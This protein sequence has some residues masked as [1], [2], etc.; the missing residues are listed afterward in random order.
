MSGHCDSSSVP[1]PSCWGREESPSSPAFPACQPPLSADKLTKLQSGI[2]PSRRSSQSRPRGDPSRPGR[3]DPGCARPWRRGSS[4]I[5]HQRHAPSPA[6]NRFITGLRAGRRRDGPGRASPAPRHTLPGMARA[7]EGDPG[8]NGSLGVAARKVPGRGTAPASAPG[9][10]AGSQDGGHVRR[11]VNSRP[12]SAPARRRGHPPRGGGSARPR[13]RALDLPGVQAKAAAGGRNRHT[14]SR[15]RAARSASF[16]PGS[17]AG[18]FRP[19]AETSPREANPQR[20]GTPWA[21]VPVPG[22]A[23]CPERL[24]GE[25]A[26]PARPR[27]GRLQI[28][29]GSRRCGRIS[30]LG[31]RD[32]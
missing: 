9:S 31:S 7:R 27:P 15:G 11:P 17:R 3:R 12:A 10:G 1:A 30:F 20:R 2:P 29:H 22:P 13:T 4:Q 23:P 26:G 21:A 18:G 5:R 32:P 28:S 24:R 25:A 8:G 19:G 6:F 14:G 16:P